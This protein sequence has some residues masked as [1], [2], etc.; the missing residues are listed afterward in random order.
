MISYVPMRCAGALRRAYP[1]FV[2][3]T[4]FVSMNL[5]RHIKSHV[6]LMDHL[7]NGDT[8]K[9]DAIRT[10]LRRI[11]CCDGFAGGILH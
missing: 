5:E 3:V 2:Q 9:A 6:E 10:F 7:A 1:G 4:G 11:F 8:E